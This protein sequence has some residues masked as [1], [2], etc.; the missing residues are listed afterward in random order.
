MNETTTNFLVAISALAAVVI[1]TLVTF[2]VT[3]SQLG[4]AADLARAQIESAA[5]ATTLQISSTSEIAQR[6]IRAESVSANRQAWIN[7]LRD[8]IAEI[9]S[10]AAV[11]A[12]DSEDR[13]YPATERVEKSHRISFLR[14][15]VALLVN[16]S[17]ADHEQLLRSIGQL[18][19]R[20]VQPG[21]SDGRAFPRMQGEI[22]TL[23][24]TVLKREWERVKSG[25]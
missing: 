24:Q 2:L 11:L 21:A 22:T 10:L 9:Q 6:Q 12:M 8:T 16:P 17:E 20:S 7:N 5:Q 1:N 15:K 14:A 23:A 4:S 3:R 25:D 13:V 19:D 18:V